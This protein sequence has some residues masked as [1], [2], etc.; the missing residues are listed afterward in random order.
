MLPSTNGLATFFHSDQGLEGAVQA[1]EIIGPILQLA[2]TH[3]PPMPEIL[4]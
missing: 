1:T 4:K 3:P 2:E